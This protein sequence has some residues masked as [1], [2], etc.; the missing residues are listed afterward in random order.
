MKEILKKLGISERTINQMFKLCPNI[1]NLSNEKIEEKIEILKKI[2]CD[3]IQIRNIISS[4][5]LYLDRYVN[6]LIAEMQKIGF[7]DLN[8]L[9]DGN[10]YILNLDYFEIKNYIKERE[11]NGELIDDIIDDLSSNPFI[12]QEI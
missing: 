6:K 5:P 1:E 3:D 9:F 10:P 4:N 2:K 7:T 8:I 12:F 11:K